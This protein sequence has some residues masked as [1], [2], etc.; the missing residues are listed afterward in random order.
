MSKEAS[1]PEFSDRIDKMTEN[2]GTGKQRCKKYNDKSYSGKQ[3]SIGEQSRP[4]EGAAVFYH[5][6]VQKYTDYCAVYD[7]D[8]KSY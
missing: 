2:T 8:N 5:T 4:V 7:S 6:E 1:F 3:K